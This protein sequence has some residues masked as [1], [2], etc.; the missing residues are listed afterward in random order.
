MAKV[1]HTYPLTQQMVTVVTSYF[2]DVVYICHR[3][4]KAHL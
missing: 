3:I 2:I 1:S 4:L